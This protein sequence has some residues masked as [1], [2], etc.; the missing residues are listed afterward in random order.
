MLPPG[1]SRKSEG[2]QT[3]AGAPDDAIADGASEAMIDCPDGS[4]CNTFRCP[5]SHETRAENQQPDLF[6]R[7]YMSPKKGTAHEPSIGPPEYLK[8][9]VR[10]QLRMRKKKARSKSS[11]GGKF[12]P[13][14]NHGRD[15]EALRSRLPENSSRQEEVWPARTKPSSLEDRAAD[16]SKHAVADPPVHPL[17]IQDKD[18]DPA[19]PAANALSTLQKENVKIHNPSNHQVLPPSSAE[20]PP[21]SPKISDYKS[22]TLP[23]VRVAFDKMHLQLTGQVEGQAKGLEINSSSYLHTGPPTD[24]D[25]NLVAPLIPPPQAYPRF[26]GGI[27]NDISSHDEAGPRP[28]TVTGNSSQTMRSFAPAGDSIAFHPQPESEVSQGFTDKQHPRT[29]HYPQALQPFENLRAALREPAD[30]Q[31][32]LEAPLFRLAPVYV[33]YVCLHVQ[34][35]ALINGDSSGLENTSAKCAKSRLS[36]AKISIDI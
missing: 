14:P 24:R 15:I 17:S 13:Q 20:L 35:E 25:S 2:G 8:S 27:E 22:Q 10:T 5:H 30:H 3:P 33:L 18:S 6:N 36:T 34:L 19:G 11:N 26:V 32:V 1:D 31:P 21:I 9:A 12:D 7:G 28:L 4:A 16:A 23:S 29:G